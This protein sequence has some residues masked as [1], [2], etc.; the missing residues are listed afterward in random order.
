MVEIFTHAPIEVVLVL[1]SLSLFALG[2]VFAEFKYKSTVIKIFCFAILFL[3]ICLCLGKLNENE[4]SFAFNKLYI[5]APYIN[6]FKLILL[7]VASSILL[8]YIAHDKIQHKF[9]DTEFVAL[10]FMLLF[11]SFILLSANDLIPFYLGI[12]LHFICLYALMSYN[13]NISEYKEEVIKYFFLNIFFSIII[14]L[15]ISLLYISLGTTNFSTLASTYTLASKTPASAV[16]GA[17]LL[18]GGT[19]FRL[20]GPPVNTHL[21]DIYG[22]SSITSSAIFVLVSKSTMLLLL[23]KLFL[24]DLGVLRGVTLFIIELAAIIFMFIGSMSIINQINVKRILV[25]AAIY[26]LGWILLGLASMSEIGLRGFFLAFIILLTSLIGLYG[27][28][29]IIRPCDDTVIDVFAFK[30]L[31][32]TNPI[33]AHSFAILFLSIAGLPPSSGFLGRFDI[34][35]SVINA[36]LYF[37]LVCGV[38]T[39]AIFTFYSLRII[40]LMYFDNPSGEGIILSRAPIEF[41]LLVSLSVTLNLLLISA[42]DSLDMI[43]IYL[44][45]LYN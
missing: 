5:T 15:G 41:V 1:F 44:K 12:E 4:S 18:M 10:V 27:L 26:N 22:K 25:Q 34:I 2:V 28:V 32:K 11:S 31:G 23:L 19:V 3:S 33:L 42:P 6:F 45:G 14:L 20:L 8:F 29:S 13:K 16:L 35:F 17:S 24:V 36:K 39:M 38:I 7:I 30:G 37:L 21:A 40:K 43:S 9:F